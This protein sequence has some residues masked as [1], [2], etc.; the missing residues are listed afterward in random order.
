MNHVSPRTP[1]VRLQGIVRT[2]IS[3]D[4]Q[5]DV[6]D[7]CRLARV[8]G[9]TL[10]SILIVEDDSDYPMVFALLAFGVAVA[11][12]DARHLG[13]WLP[14]LRGA[15]EVWTLSPWGRVVGDES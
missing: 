11:V 3:D 13:D 2:D 9:T 6:H 4:P 15:V 10:D 14:L 5:G 7:I 12:P 1:L 8:L